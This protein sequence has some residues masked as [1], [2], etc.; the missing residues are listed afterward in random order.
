MSYSLVYVNSRNRKPL[1]LIFQ[2][3]KSSP[4]ILA[5][6]INLKVIR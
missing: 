6:W 3:I 1:K 4:G 2:Q 5:A